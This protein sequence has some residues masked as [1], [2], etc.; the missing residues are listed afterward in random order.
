MKKGALEPDQATPERCRH[1][2]VQHCAH[3]DPQ[4]TGSALTSAPAA[5]LELDSL[6]THSPSIAKNGAEGGER[7]TLC[8]EVRGVVSL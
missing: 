5:K 6:T 3:H 1:Q 4:M 8:R 2:A 7:I